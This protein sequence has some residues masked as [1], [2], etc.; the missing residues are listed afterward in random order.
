[1]R[2]GRGIAIGMTYCGAL[3]G[4]GF[5]TGR[6]VWLF[7]ASHGAR[8]LAGVLVATALFCWFG[9]VILDVTH[10]CAVYS[11][12]DLLQQLLRCKLLVWLA[13]GVFCLTLVAGVGIMTAAAMAITAQWQINSVT[14]GGAFL[15]ACI[16]VLRGGTRN[17]V[18]ANSILVPWLSVII[19]VLC[20]L[21]VD[22]VST[23]WIAPGPYWAPL[24][25]VGYNVALA[26]VCLATLKGQLDKT[27]VWVGGI[28]GGMMIGALLCM[29]YLALRGY[30]S[31]PDIP[32]AMLAGRFFGRWEWIYDV[33]LMAAV[34][35]TALANMHGFA[36]RVGKKGYW[37]ACIAV[38]GLS[39]FSAAVGF[40][41]LVGWLYPLLGLCNIVLLV[42]LC[43]YS[44]NKLLRGRC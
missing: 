5:A 7:F 44:F 38:A 8:G 17:F 20:L 43:Y 29:V 24:L 34:F 16:I 32:L 14:T 9:Y 25:Y 27:S 12:R 1:M 31:V 35:T 13:D 40:G 2:W 23:P 28:S 41:N 33:S 26:G 36:S 30:A 42:G 4:A 15:L 18:R 3:V 37:P 39:L 21:A 10:R 6:E 22:G 11:Y 19:T